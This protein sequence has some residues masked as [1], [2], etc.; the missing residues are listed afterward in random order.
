MVPYEGV[1]ILERGNDF[2]KFRTKDGQVIE[3]HGS[4]RIETSK[5]GY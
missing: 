2:V 3:Q 1:E 5:Q 4:Y